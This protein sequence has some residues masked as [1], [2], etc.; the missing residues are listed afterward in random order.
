MDAERGYLKTMK[1]SDSRRGLKNDGD[2]ERERRKDAER[3]RRK[4]AGRE[5]NN[6]G[7]GYLKTQRARR[8]DARR[9]QEI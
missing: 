2:T 5:L 6:A 4:G 7:R 1:E 9:R 8:K 3:E